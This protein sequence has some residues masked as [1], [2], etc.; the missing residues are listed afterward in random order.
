MG[1]PRKPRISF[2]QL[3]PELKEYALGSLIKAFDVK[4]NKPRTIQSAINYLSYCFKSN[5]NLYIEIKPSNI[6][7]MIRILRTQYQ[8]IIQKKG[9]YGLQCVY[10]PRNNQTMNILAFCENFTSHQQKLIS[11]YKNQIIQ[12]LEVASKGL[13]PGASSS[14]LEAKTHLNR[15]SEITPLSQVSEKMKQIGQTEYRQIVIPT[16]RAI[17]I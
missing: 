16:Q 6:Q 13:I 2:R 1:R 4:S 3:T 11:E 15:L 17:G 12:P 7:S 10:S 5:A 9:N 14:A 8:F